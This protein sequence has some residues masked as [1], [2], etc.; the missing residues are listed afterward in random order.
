MPSLDGRRL[1]VTN[2]S[3]TGLHPDQRPKGTVMRT[4][5]SSHSTDAEA[6]AAVERLLADGT[7]GTRINVIT[8][9][10]TADHRG[11]RVGAYAGDAGTFAVPSGAT[12]DTMGSFSRA[13]AEQRRGGFGDGDRDR[14]TSYADGV[15]RV[16]VASHHE[17][18]RRLAAAGLD[19]DAIAADVAALHHG[20]ALV[21]VTAP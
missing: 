7:P 9:Q 18:E 8:G 21:L 12:A 20:R 14:V 17:L 2:R 15:R 5:C 1:L 10:K 11:E 6:F 3:V 13:A 16:H 4:S 19:A